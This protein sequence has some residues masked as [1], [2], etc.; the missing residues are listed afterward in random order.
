MF[1]VESTHSFTWACP[2][3]QCDIQNPEKGDGLRITCHF[4]AVHES[5]GEFSSP[6]ASCQEGEL[7][8]QRS[9]DLVGS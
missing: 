2:H 8:G 5:W 7:A 1:S 3:V 6:Q 4:Y 9:P